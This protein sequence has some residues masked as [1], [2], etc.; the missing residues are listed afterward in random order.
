[1]VQTNKH[2]NTKRT[3]IFQIISTKVSQSLIFCIT[4]I[5]P[6]YIFVNIFRAKDELP[7]TDLSK[8]SALAHLGEHF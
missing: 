8:R 3:M 4:R 2:T 7:D 5:I 6:V 1:M